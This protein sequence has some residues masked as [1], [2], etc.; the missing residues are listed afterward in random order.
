MSPSSVDKEPKAMRSSNACLHSMKSIT[1]G[2]LAYIAT[3]ARSKLNTPYFFWPFIKV[4]FSLS[5]SSVF[6]RTDTV[7]D[8]K[9]FYHSILYLLED[10]EESE[11]VGNLMMWWTWF[12]IHLIKLELQSNTLYSRVFPNSSLLQHSISKNSVL[13]KIWEKRAALQ[14]L[15]M[16]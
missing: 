1:K 8:S 10:P 2:S 6:L 3:Q 14:E 15:A 13:S 9:N 16:N 11:E 7:M 4:Q 5:L 12:M